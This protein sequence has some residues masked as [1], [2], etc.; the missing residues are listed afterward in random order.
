MFT[1]ENINIMATNNVATHT[2]IHQRAPKSKNLQ[3]KQ[4]YH[5]T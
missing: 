2:N 3:F 4:K 5:T 1:E